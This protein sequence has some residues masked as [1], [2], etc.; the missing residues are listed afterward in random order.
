MLKQKPHHT[1]HLKWPYANVTGIATMR[2]RHVMKTK[3]L[4]TH[5]QAKHHEKHR[6]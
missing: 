4:R 3:R 1:F 5:H 2:T 6:S